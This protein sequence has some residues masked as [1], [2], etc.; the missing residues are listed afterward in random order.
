MVVILI[1][2]EQKTMQTVELLCRCGI[3]Q[4][5]MSFIREISEISFQ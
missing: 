4:I 3:D 5:L 1:E 2:V